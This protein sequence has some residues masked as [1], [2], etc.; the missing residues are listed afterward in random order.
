MTDR[1]HFA[2]AALTGLLS[3]GDDGSFSE[4][5]YARAAY[6]WADFMLRERGNQPGKPDSSPVAESATTA[7]PVAWAVMDGSEFMEFCTDKEEA[8]CAAGFYGDCP[9]VPLYRQP[10]PTL[11]DAEREAVADAADR[12]AALAPESAETVATLRGLLDRTQTV[13]K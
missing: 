7:E 4:E 9:I 10:Q 5:W 13:E 12:Y 1:D 11:T 6:R 8:K 3:Q 2:A